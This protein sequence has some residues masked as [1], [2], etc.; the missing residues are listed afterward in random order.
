MHPDAFGQNPYII[1]CTA[2]GFADVR[3][4]YEVIPELA[5]IVK[6]P[7]IGKPFS[8]RFNESVNQL[9]ASKNNGRGMSAGQIHAFNLF[10]QKYVPQLEGVCGSCF[11]VML[12]RSGAGERWRHEAQGGEKFEIRLSAAKP[13][14]LPGQTVEY[15]SQTITDQN[16]KNRY[17]L[18]DV[19]VNGMQYTDNMKQEATHIPWT[20]Y[21][22]QKFSLDMPICLCKARFLNEN[23]QF[24]QHC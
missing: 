12:P 13:M 22:Y 6:D 10:F 18:W 21:D 1:Y 2:G 5:N 17:A 23:R 3:W 8:M 15:V 16:Q 19:K 14:G 11:R 4:F 7:T 24:N 20:I 9:F